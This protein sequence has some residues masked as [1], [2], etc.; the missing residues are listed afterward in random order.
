MVC[1]WS[2][3]WLCV[4]DGDRIREGVSVC[5][6]LSKHLISSQSGLLLISVRLGHVIKIPSYTSGNHSGVPAHQSMCPCN[7]FS[8]EENVTVHKHNYIGGWSCIDDTTWFGIICMKK[9]SFRGAFHHVSVSF[10]STGSA[11]LI[12]QRD[13]W[14]M[15]SCVNLLNS[16]HQLLFLLSDLMCGW[17]WWG[18]GREEVW[19]VGGRKRGEGRKKKGETSFH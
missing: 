2:C 13:D 19:G 10:S 9:N 16:I 17:W 11:W 3:M 5:V 7:E 18:K 12:V 6:H 14:R 8:F 15:Y 1:W 4:W